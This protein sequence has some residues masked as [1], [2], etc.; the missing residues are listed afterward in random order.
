M[1]KIQKTEEE[2]V[3]LEKSRLPAAASKRFSNGMEKINKTEEEWRKELS[4]EVFAVTRKQGTEAP[5]SGKYVHEKRKGI[6]KCSNCELEL[7]SS[8]TKFDSG[9]GWPSFDDPVNLKHVELRADVAHGMNRTEVVCSRCGAHLGHVFPDGPK[10]TTGQRY[11]MNSCSL[12]FE[13]EK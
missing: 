2:L 12:S 1:Q 5:F 9:T 4:E 3:P 10:E 6:Y 11:C 13:E 7:F 8:E